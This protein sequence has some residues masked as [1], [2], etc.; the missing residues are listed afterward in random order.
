MLKLK[1]IIVIIGFSMILFGCQEQPLQPLVDQNYSV[2]T[3][4]KELVSDIVSDSLHES[5]TLEDFQLNQLFGCLKLIY[6]QVGTW[7]TCMGNYHEHKIFYK[8]LYQRE[9]KEEDSLYNLKLKKY[10]GL[11]NDSLVVDA[12]MKLTTE[13]E[14][15]IFSIRRNYMKRINEYRQ[16]TLDVIETEMFWEPI[17]EMVNDG[18]RQLS[19]WKTWRATG[20]VV[21]FDY[22]N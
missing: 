14:Q 1:T 4:N 12:I 2:E 20:K 8:S 9:L 17:Q 22:I 7:K 5:M 6:Q 21:C 13:H 16:Q 11:P 3:D 19:I 15:N 10:D 18:G